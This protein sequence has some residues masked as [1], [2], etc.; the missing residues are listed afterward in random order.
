MRISH[1]AYLE[2]E[3]MTGNIIASYDLR[4]ILLNDL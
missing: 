1:E 3:E 4:E 2:T